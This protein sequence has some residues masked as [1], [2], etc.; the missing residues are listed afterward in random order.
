MPDPSDV[1]LDGDCAVIV[2][3]SFDAPR[4]LVWR[5]FTEPAIL[6]RWLLGPP[7]WE[8]HVCEVEVKVGGSYRWRWRNAEL[9]QEFG[10]TGTYTAVEIGARL[11]DRQTFD[12]GTHGVAMGEP[13]TNIVVFEDV[14]DASGPATRVVTRIEYPD[15]A[16]RTMVMSQ[17][18]SDGMEM[19]YA[20]LDKV[21]PQLA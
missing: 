1:T 19:S 4:A 13:T 10:F 6:Q 8:M 14:P 17:G 5:A 2:T 12:Q 15:A 7:G 9:G 20:G 21:L 18:M 11:E 16:T 3:R